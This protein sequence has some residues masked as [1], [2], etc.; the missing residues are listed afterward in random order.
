MTIMSAVFRYHQS[1]DDD[2]YN[3]H[4]SPENGK[5]LVVA[6]AE[7]AETGSDTDIKIRQPLIPKSR[8]RIAQKS[9]T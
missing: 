8:D 5:R 1:A 2:G 4:K 7:K 6:L 9:H 3:T